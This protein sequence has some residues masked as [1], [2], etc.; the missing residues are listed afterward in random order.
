M[1]RKQWSKNEIKWIGWNLI[2]EITSK[3]LFWAGFSQLKSLWGCRTHRRRCSKLSAVLHSA[4]FCQLFS[5]VLLSRCKVPDQ[6]SEEKA[7]KCCRRWLYVIQKS[8]NLQHKAAHSQLEGTRFQ[9]WC[10]QYLLIRGSFSWFGS[11]S[12]T[13]ASAI[14]GSLH[15]Q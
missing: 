12:H 1:K 10:Q 7:S 3:N 9:P 13:L 14:P 8:I 11:P 15:N 4:A 5:S 6:K 2:C